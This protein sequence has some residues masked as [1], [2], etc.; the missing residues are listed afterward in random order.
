[1]TRT[2]Q[3]ADDAGPVKVRGD[4][5]GERKCLRCNATFWS[6]GFGERICQRCK[7]LKMWRSAAAVSPGVGRKR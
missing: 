7:G 2:E 6:A 5:P 4:A 3:P 1:M